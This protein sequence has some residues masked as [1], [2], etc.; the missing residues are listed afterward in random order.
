MQELEN[1]IG[2]IIKDS[3]NFL[4]TTHPRVDGDAVGAVLALGLVLGNLGKSREIIIQGDIPEVY[5]FVP[6]IKMVRSYS[7]STKIDYEVLF[8]LDATGMDRIGIPEE[9]LLSGRPF[10]NIDHHVDNDNF[11]TVNFVLPS[12]SSTC[13]IIYDIIKANNFPVDKNTATA[14]YVGIVTDTGRFSYSNTTKKSLET[15]AELVGLGAEP[16]VV[17]NK[18]YQSYSREIVKLH[19]LLMLGIS[20]RS[21]GRIAFSSITNR[22]FE[23]T[24]CRMIDTQEFSG[25]PLEVKGVE[26]SILFTEMPQSHKVKVSFRS[27]GKVKVNEIANIFAGG[28]H[29]MAA[30]C[31]IEGR[32]ADVREL[33]LSEAKKAL[34]LS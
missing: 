4:I 10:I 15:A 6:G 25:I 8:S 33:V 13:E 34:E 9:K 28:G 2:A 17:F 27:R 18:V 11:G 23:R 30:G 12:A 14:L 7:Q 22:M 20:Y 3:D 29:N 1:K 21:N 16:N 26:V 19:G 5:R 31:V 32:I 24:G